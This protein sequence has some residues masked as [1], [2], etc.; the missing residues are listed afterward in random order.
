MFIVGLRTI[1]A[2]TASMIACLEPLYGTILA[3]LLIQEV[4][5]SRVVAGGLV[6]LGVAFYATIKERAKD[7]DAVSGK[8]EHPGRRAALGLAAEPLLAKPASIV[9]ASR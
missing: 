5:T 3:A 1:S 8:V 2:R 6:T 9:L 7:N 4:P